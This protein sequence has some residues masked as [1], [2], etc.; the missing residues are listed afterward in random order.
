MLDKFFKFFSSKNVLFHFKILQDI[1]QNLK[2]W[3]NSIFFSFSNL[4]K[5]FHCLLAS[6]DSDEESMKIQI[7]IHCMQDAIF[8]CHYRTFSTVLL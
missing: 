4:K 3:I 2:F 7:M 5:L 1:L 8:S 6:T